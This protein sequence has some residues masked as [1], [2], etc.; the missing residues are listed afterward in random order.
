MN[1]LLTA[2]GKRVQLIKWLKNSCKIIGTDASEM[3]PARYF[4]DKFYKVKKFSEEGYIEQILNICEKEKVDFLV[5]LYEKEF[6]MLCDYRTCFEAK[7]TKLILSGKGIIEICNDKWKTY[8]FFKKNN[9]ECPNTYLKNNI[10]YDVKFPLIIKPFNGMGSQSVFKIKNQKE[11]DFFL[12]YVENAI[13]QEFI[14]GTE[15]TVDVLCDLK[16]SVIF[17]IPRERLEVRA[18]EVSK[19]RTVKNKI[20]I[21]KVNELCEKLKKECVNENL[22]GPLTMQCILNEKGEVYFIEINPRF[23]GGAP[24]TF[25]AGGDYGLYFNKMKEEAHI[26][27]IDN[28]EEITMLRYDE[29]IY[30]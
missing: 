22:M 13:V 16:G 18:G 17:A 29:G 30:L 8:E 12:E 7:G 27:P 20:I 23:G 21:K 26:E 15:F 11:L 2:I 5:P 10:P 19:T 4:V 25:K 1:I 28:F 9:I 14:E 24:L 3:A 6:S